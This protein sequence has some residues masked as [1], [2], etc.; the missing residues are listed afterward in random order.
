MKKVLFIDRDGTIIIEPDITFQIDTLEKLEF[1]PFAI[2]SMSALRKSDFEIVMVSNQDGL[3]TK[4]YPIAN[5]NLVQGKMLSILGSEGVFFDDVFIDGSTPEENSPNR[6]PGIGMLAKYI[7]NDDYDLKGSF[8]LGDRVTDVVL[9]KNLGAKAILF[10]PQD[11]GRKMLLG[12]EL[13]D[14]VALISDSW[15]EVAEF[16]RLADRRVEVSRKTKET[17]ILLSLDLDGRGISSINTGLSFFN[18]MLEQIVFHSPISMSIDVRGDLNVDEHHTIEDVAIVLGEAIGKA[19]GD[20]CGIERYGFSLPMDECE[21]TVLLDFGGRI[22]FRFD[23]DF[24]REK[25]GDVPT[26][27]FEHFFKS[28]CHASRCNLHISASGD[29]EHHK[30]EGVFKA[31]ARALKMAIRRNVYQMS[32][33]SSKGML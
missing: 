3:G 27:M 26:E 16:L 5:F 30:I 23:V 1:L 14:S 31:Y 24:K 18:H 7:G 9:A 33:P 10:Q 20:K 4:D 22:D 6:K 2:S 29:N 32:L 25:I 19:L 21:A 17:D 8:V 15:I 13:E 11:K 12:S 28:L